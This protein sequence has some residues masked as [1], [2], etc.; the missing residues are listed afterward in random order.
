MFSGQANPLVMAAK[1]GRRLTKRPFVPLVVFIIFAMG[2]LFT[3]V[4]IRLIPGQAVSAL[5]IA[6]AQNI[7]LIVTFGF[8]SLLFWLWVRF[9]EGRMFV[10]LGFRAG[11]IAPKIARGAFV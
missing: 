9:Y 3:R 8:V 6:S 7:L 1:S 11:H 5:E 4:F 2:I 10:T